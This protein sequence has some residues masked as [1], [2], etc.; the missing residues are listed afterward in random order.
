MLGLVV[1]RYCDRGNVG[2]LRAFVSRQ[3]FRVEVSGVLGRCMLGVRSRCMLVV[4]RGLSIGMYHR[5]VALG[6]LV[7]GGDSVLSISGKTD[8]LYVS[9]VTRASVIV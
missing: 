3:T 2:R 9:I 8:L 1:Y 6:V 5:M 4:L 7:L